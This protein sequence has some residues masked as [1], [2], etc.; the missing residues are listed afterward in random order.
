VGEEDA[1]GFEQEGHG[2]AEGGAATLVV[3]VEAPG[4]EED[5]SGEVLAEE[6]VEPGGDGVRDG[7]VAAELASHPV[8]DEG[9]IEQVGGEDQIGEEDAAPGEGEVMVLELLPVPEQRGEDEVENEA[10]EREA[11]SYPEGL[12]LR[13]G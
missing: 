2:D 7:D 11:R 6:G 4:E 10:D 3:E 12:S 5:F 8:P 9:A 13:P 1:K